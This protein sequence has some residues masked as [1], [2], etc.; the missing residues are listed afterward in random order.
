MK[1]PLI[2]SIILCTALLLSA[3]TPTYIMPPADESSK[4]AGAQYEAEESAEESSIKP[5]ESSKANEESSAESSQEASSE[6]SSEVS[7]EASSEVSEEPSAESSQESSS[8]ASSEPVQESSSEPSQESTESSAESSTEP[9]QESSAPTEESSQEPSQESSTEPAP[10]IPPGTPD[11]TLQDWINASDN[12]T[13]YIIRQTI[14]DYLYDN[15]MAAALEHLSTPPTYTWQDIEWYI[16]DDSEIYYLFDSYDGSQR[17]SIPSGI[18]ITG[19]SYS[20]SD[21][22]DWTGRCVGPWETANAETA[23]FFYMTF[24]SDGVFY[25]GYG[26]AYSEFFGFEE[27]TFS[28]SQDGSQITI[29]LPNRAPATFTFRVNHNHIILVQSSDTGIMTGDG[30]GIVYVLTMYP[31]Y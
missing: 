27:G 8:E 29:T 30:P 11:Y 31:P 9:V 12:V 6:A 21:Y 3:C 14:E 4:F 7:Q 20:I 1:K 28:F 18:S 15:D 17:F 16:G 24:S 23:N 26:W 5:Q 10:P 25:L 22:F 2:I 13:N 19:A